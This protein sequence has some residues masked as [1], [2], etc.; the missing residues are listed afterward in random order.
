MIFFPKIY[1]S[2]TSINPSPL[3][4]IN[5]FKIC[6]TVLAQMGSSFWLT[7]KLMLGAEWKAS[8]DWFFFVSF[9]QTM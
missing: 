7:A 4:W 9:H 3:H 5:Q 2:S 8:Q 6:L 1:S